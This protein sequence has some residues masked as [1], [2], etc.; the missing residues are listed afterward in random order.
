M[1]QEFLEEVQSQGEW[2]LIFF[3]GQFSHAIMKTPKPGDFRSQEEFGG[4]IKNTRPSDSLIQAACRALAAATGTALYAR[5]DGVEHRGQFRLMELELI[6][7]ALY[8]N[9]AEGAV[10]RFAAA[11]ANSF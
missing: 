8:M 6:E 7:P 4:S 9:L 1:V 11:I 2:S 10:E 5:V 3:S